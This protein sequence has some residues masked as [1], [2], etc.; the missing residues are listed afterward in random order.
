MPTSRLNRG[1]NRLTSRI[2]SIFVLR[3]HFASQHALI[4]VAHLFNLISML[5]S[6]FFTA[7]QIERGEMQ[8]WFKLIDSNLYTLQP[9]T[10]VRRADGSELLVLIFAPRS[11]G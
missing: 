8:T 4:L 5:Q 11:Q 1:Q 3:N 7:E 10:T 2:N 9:P 6:R